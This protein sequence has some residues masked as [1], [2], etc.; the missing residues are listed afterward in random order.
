MSSERTL[1]CMGVSCTGA[2]NASARPRPQAGQ[3]AKVSM[4]ACVFS[5]TRSG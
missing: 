5:A 4:I 2:G 1:P 3:R